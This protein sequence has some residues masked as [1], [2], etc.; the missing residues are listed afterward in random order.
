MIFIKDHLNRL[1]VQLV[2]LIGVSIM[3]AF[4]VS[5]TATL[6]F[7][8]LN[9][10]ASRDQ[11]A[12]IRVEELRDA[13]DVLSTEEQQKFAR[14]ASS[15]TTTISVSSTPSVMET[16]DNDRS[17]SLSA[18]LTAQGRFEDV[19]VSILPLGAVSPPLDDR[20]SA[21][22]REV[23]SVSARLAGGH[24]LNFRSREPGTWFT[25]SDLRFIGTTLLLTFVFMI[26]GSAF[27]VT[28]IIQPI[29]ELATS[30][31]KSASGNMSTRVSVRGPTELQ[32]AAR[33][34]N[35]MQDEIERFDEERKRTVAAV[36]HDLRT[37]LTSLRIRAEEID[38]AE[39][40]DR[41]IA[42]IDELTQMADGLLN[43]AKGG[44]EED[45]N[46]SVDLS[47]LVA[48][49]CAEAG[50]PLSTSGA[51]VVRGG[52]VRLTRAIRNIIDNAVKFAGAATVE[53]QGL[54]KTARVIVTDQG[55]GIDPAR[56]SELMKPFSRG[57]E[58]R[59]ATTGG[60]GLGLYIAHQIVSAH[61]G[62]IALKENPTGG[63]IVEV[64][65]PALSKSGPSAH[66][67]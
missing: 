34:Y 10:Q 62:T 32:D 35:A 65:L 38:D 26:A 50:V 55:P 23:I 66:R 9:D 40:R 52:Q 53:V 5:A 58:S 3:I 18:Q 25:S 49:I 59:N 56:R 30:A 13:L 28:R 41:M 51:A 48:S 43:Y 16:A 4:L 19:S 8:N 47:D 22:N 14:V 11:A 17:R 60:A 54:S 46:H 2:L 61:N 12:A 20:N 21:L 36:G 42:N 45:M 64:E 29:N 24:W 39:L 67:G 15:R 33:A 63:L 6:L 1:G 44:L 27:L 57:E 37:P 7:R 31:R